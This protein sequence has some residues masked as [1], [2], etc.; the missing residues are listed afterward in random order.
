[1]FNQLKFHIKRLRPTDGNSVFSA[2]KHS[3]ECNTCS[4]DDRKNYWVNMMGYVSLSLQE[5]PFQ[6]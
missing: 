6:N 3:S 4:N 5:V 2:V 1:M